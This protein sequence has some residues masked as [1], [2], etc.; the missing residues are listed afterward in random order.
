MRSQFDVSPDYAHFASFFI[1]SHPRP[2]REAIETLLR[3]Q[4]AWNAVL[5]RLGAGDDP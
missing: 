5:S 1:V 3:A 4:G 2:V